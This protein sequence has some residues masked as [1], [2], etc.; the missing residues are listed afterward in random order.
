V[1]ECE[2]NWQFFFLACLPLGFGSYGS[3]NNLKVIWSVF[4][5][6]GVGVVV[7][8]AA[9]LFLFVHK[10]LK[11]LSKLPLY[12][13]GTTLFTAVCWATIFSLL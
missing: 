5:C 1:N 3:P 11:L 4:F 8:V 7:V 10:E 12:V 2:K 9:L 6:S 13:N